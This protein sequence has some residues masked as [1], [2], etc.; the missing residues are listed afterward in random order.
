MFSIRSSLSNSSRDVAMA[1]NFM[2]YQT[3]SLKAEV[4]QDPLDLFSQSM[5][6]MVGIKLQIINPTFFFRY[7]KGRCHGNQLCGK[8]TYP[9][10]LSLW[11]SETE[12]SY[13]NGRINSVNNAPISCDNFV[14]FG[15]VTPELTELICEGQ[16]RHGQKMAYLFEYLRIYWTDFHKLFTV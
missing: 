1:T 8:I 9:L 5:H 14:Q 2:L 11:H 4:S 16:V 7:L 15:P 10:H 6:H 3:C 13:F 12:Y